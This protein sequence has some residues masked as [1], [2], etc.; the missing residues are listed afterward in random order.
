MAKMRNFPK[1]K[2]MISTIMIMK[3][4]KK[5]VKKVV[6]KRSLKV[7]NAL[8]PQMKRMRKPLSLGDLPRLFLKL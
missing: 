7:M 1:R 3:I 6:K 2:K 8:N 5:V 4:L